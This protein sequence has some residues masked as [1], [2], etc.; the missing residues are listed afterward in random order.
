MVRLAPGLQAHHKVTDGKRRKGVLETHP[1][2]RSSSL[3]LD[4]W[5]PARS[6]VCPM[7]ECNHTLIRK[8]Q[9]GTGKHVDGSVTEPLMGRP[10]QALVQCCDA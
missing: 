8:V 4:S 1:G 5:T 7:P 2:R 9:G 3:V 10:F 6:T